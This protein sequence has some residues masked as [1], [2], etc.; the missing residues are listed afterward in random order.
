MRNLNENELAID[1][2]TIGSDNNYLLR[3]MIGEIKLEESNGNDPS[4]QTGPVYSLP[5]E[6]LASI[7]R[8]LPWRERIASVE[9]VS[10]KWRRVALEGGWSDFTVLDSREWEDLW[11]RDGKMSPKVSQIT[12]CNIQTGPV[13]QSRN[14]MR[15]CG[16]HLVELLLDSATTDA[17]LYILRL[18]RAVR[19][20][21]LSWLLTT[22]DDKTADSIRLLLGESLRSLHFKHCIEQ[23]E[24][25]PAINSLFAECS[26]LEYLHIE[27]FSSVFA[28]FSPQL[29]LP[30]RLVYLSLHESCPFIA[31]L[32]NKAN[33]RAMAPTLRALQLVHRGYQSPPLLTHLNLLV[34]LIY[35]GV[36]TG[37]KSEAVVISALATMPHLKAL[38]LSGV[39][40][41]RVL[42]KHP[43]L[44]SQLEHLTFTLERSHQI[45]GVGWMLGRCS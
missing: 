39:E 23:Q 37:P 43:A 7:I 12:G 26:R 27:E 40:G 9:R 13:L 24:A 31:S 16:P 20:L 45:Y 41:D 1:Q 35:L 22:I 28:D 42:A 8:L 10:R 19:H 18:S 29:K 5:D 6:V 36:E 33:C 2:L 32:L 44:C 38:E 3:S 25:I 4:P 21:R 11:D 34:N 14:L 30:A 15:R 17:V